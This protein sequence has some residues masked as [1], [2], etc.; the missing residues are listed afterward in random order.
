[1]T[2]EEIDGLMRDNGI[3]VTG[4]AVYALCQ[5]VTEVEREIM[6]ENG[7]R[8]CAV[9]QRT[10]QFCG[11]LERAVAA[12]REACALICDAQAVMCSRGSPQIEL[13]ECAAA[14]RARREQ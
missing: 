2:R 14:I 9:G 7:W 4:E 13:E 11:Q 5:L 8:Q 3:I 1:M 12:E 10:T 6:Q